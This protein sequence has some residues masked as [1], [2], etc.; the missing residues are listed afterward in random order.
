MQKVVDFFEREGVPYRVVGSM[1]S[2]AYGEPRFTNDVD[3]LVELSEDQAERIGQEF[4]HPEYYV[5]VPA[6]REAI[7]QRHQFDILHPPSGLK[8]DVILCKDTEFGRAD[9]TLGQRLKS[10]GFYDAWFASPENV[11]LMKL[12]YFQ[13]GGSE[14]HLRDIASVL[15]VQAEAID[16]TYLDE[17]ANKL[18]VA[19]EWQLVSE[20]LQEKRQ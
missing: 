12:R 1:A 17:W 5:S 9:L 20:R 13:E 2:I 10:E 19:T 8:V 3:M 11:I 18:G 6:I 4:P 7:R 16:R 15:L 14:K